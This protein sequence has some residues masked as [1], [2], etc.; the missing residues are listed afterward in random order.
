MEDIV[1][2]HVAVVPGRDW[3]LLRLSD[4]NQTLPG[5]L[6]P[7]FGLIPQDGAI[8][9]I[10]HPGEGVKKIDPCVVIQSDRRSQT[11]ERH[12][13]GNPQTAYSSGH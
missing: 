9:I 3:A 1:G 10:G 12:Y 4:D 5:E 11:V 2:E 8:C 6:L 7:R 13:H